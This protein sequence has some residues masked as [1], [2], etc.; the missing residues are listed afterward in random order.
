MPKPKGGR[1][2][3]APYEKSI[4]VRCPL[5][6]KPQVEQLKQRYQDYL[7][8]GGDPFAPPPLL[9][10]SAEKKTVDELSAV[11]VWRVGDFCAV[12]T[13]PSGVVIP[14]VEI[15]SINASKRRCRWID[16]TTNTFLDADLADLLPLAAYTLLEQFTKERN[17]LDRELNQLHA[18]N[19]DLHLQLEQLR[20]E[21]EQ[22]RSEANAKPVDELSAQPDIPVDEL[23]IVKYINGL[24]KPNLV[25]E[26]AAKAVDE[27][28]PL[29]QRALA[30]RLNTS[31]VTVGK[32]QSR[33]TF[34]T[35]SA[36]RD[37]LGI[38]W[39]YNSRI[40]K[41]RPLVSSDQH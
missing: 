28:K 25:D 21:L 2:V 26:F 30:K 20:L 27:L 18:Q 9:D 36:E 37:P 1:G 41:F 5:P 16:R 7:D 12:I 22:M 31:H 35:W 4:M 32:H 34:P 6:L 29:S 15:L 8:Q 3:T 17:E 14:K 33:N 23:P 39:E 38:S 24:A 13:R 40:K 11:P 19:G 10:A